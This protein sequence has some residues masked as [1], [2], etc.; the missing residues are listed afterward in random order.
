M[1]VSRHR[2]RS[3]RT[4]L[5]LCAVLV[6]STLLHLVQ[7]W[8]TLENLL[9]RVM[10]HPLGRAFRTGNPSVRRSIDQQISRKANDLLQ[11]GGCARQFV[12]LVEAGATLDPRLGALTLRLRAAELD[13]CRVDAL[14]SQLRMLQEYFV[15]RNPAQIVG[16]SRRPPAFSSGPPGWY[17]ENSLSGFIQAGAR[18]KKLG[19]EHRQWRAKWT[20]LS[21][22][23]T[24]RFLEELVAP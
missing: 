7:Y 2:E 10:E 5:G 24:S 13:D 15:P 8:R 12:E 14:C 19:R 16:L 9:K 18:R 21:A 17:R 22:P 23:T 3:F 6:G 4:G 1:R 11:L 20:A